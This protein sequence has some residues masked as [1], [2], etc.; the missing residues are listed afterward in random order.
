MINVKR[1]NPQEEVNPYEGLGA[2]DVID[3]GLLDTDTHVIAGEIDSESIALAMRWMIYENTS[4][5]QKTLTL[6]INSVG[7]DLFDGLGLIDLMRSSKHVIRTVG[8]G[9]VMSTAFL[10][11][12]SGTK[13]FR[14]IGANA[15]ILS[16]QYSDSIEGKH[17]DIKSYMKS[18]EQTNES[19]AKLLQECTGL[20][21]RA[22]RSRLLPHSDVWLTPKELI[23]LGGADHLL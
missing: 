17:H 18:A 13:G 19:M 1:T 9:N 10:I 12:C 20:D 3:R 4:P 23:Q 2:A 5:I 7:G 22:V 8:V 6:Y 14:Y 16:H 21:A 11:F 15:S